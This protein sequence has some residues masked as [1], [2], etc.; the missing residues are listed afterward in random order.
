MVVWVG[1]YM[2]YLTPPQKCLMGSFVTPLGQDQ[3]PDLSKSNWGLG[4]LPDGPI[5]PSCPPLR[6][7][8]IERLQREVSDLK[9][10]LRNIHAEVSTTPSCCPPAA[11]EDVLA[12]EVSANCSRPR[13]KK[14]FLGTQFCPASLDREHC[15]GVL[16]HQV[17]QLVP[18]FALLLFI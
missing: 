5:S 3:Y 7:Q 4:L 15:S 16:S 12:K 6:D 2:S 11:K 10:E 9:E 18:A 8:L 1:R 13:P 17:M 14:E